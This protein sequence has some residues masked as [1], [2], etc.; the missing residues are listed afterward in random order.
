MGNL[1]SFIQLPTSNDFGYLSGELLLQYT[2]GLMLKTMFYRCVLPL[3][4]YILPKKFLRPKI[5]GSWVKNRQYVAGHVKSAF[6]KVKVYVTSS[7]ALCNELVAQRLIASRK[8]NFIG[9]DCEWDSSKKNGVALIQISSGNDC[10]LYRSSKTNGAI[11]ENLKTLLEDR[12][13][14]KFG[15]AI[16][17]DVRRLMS[18][19]VNVRGFVDLRNLAQRCIHLDEQV[20]PD[21]VEEL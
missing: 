5:L 2:F 6:D 15:V 13:V 11:P 19:G 20:S 9:L 10:I 18:H 17:E 7:E 4:R 16:Q 14:L 1:Y 12:K 8:V 3:A 21:G